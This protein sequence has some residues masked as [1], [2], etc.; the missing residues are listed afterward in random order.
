MKT[1]RN[2]NNDCLKLSYPLLYTYE[3]I[4]FIRSVVVT[5]LIF[6][7][8]SFH[9]NIIFRKRFIQYFSTTSRGP[10]INR[11]G[12]MYYTRPG[13]HYLYFI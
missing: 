9:R 4:Y 8:S 1:L 5:A 11:N 13:T 6:F 7:Y 3:R 10:N 12:F 2:N